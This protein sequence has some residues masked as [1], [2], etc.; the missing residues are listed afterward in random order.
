MFVLNNN[1]EYLDV[2]DVY[3]EK[4]YKRYSVNE[5]FNKNLLLFGIDFF[6]VLNKE[7]FVGNLKYFNLFFFIV[8]RVKNV[9]FYYVNYY[10]Y[11]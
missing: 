11:L 10:N 2:I 9:N 7:F 6:R 8:N 3:L 4:I 1:Y 5:L